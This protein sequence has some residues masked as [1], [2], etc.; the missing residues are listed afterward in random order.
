MQTSID[1]G[2]RK[3]FVAVIF[4]LPARHLSAQVFI[5]FNGMQ[6]GLECLR[7]LSNFLLSNLTGQGG[8]KKKVKIK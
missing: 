8:T 4:V 6:A 7:L 2:I 1:V 5:L 3:P